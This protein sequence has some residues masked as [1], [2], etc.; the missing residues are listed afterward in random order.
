MYKFFSQGTVKNNSNLNTL[1]PT[2]HP[3]VRDGK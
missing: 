2:V 1:Y 3:K